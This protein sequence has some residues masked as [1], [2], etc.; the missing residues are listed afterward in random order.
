MIQRRAPSPSSN[1]LTLDV[2]G[3]GWIAVM[4]WTE[5]ALRREEADIAESLGCLTLPALERVSILIYESTKK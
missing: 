1:I 3:E 2:Q 4:A 5:S